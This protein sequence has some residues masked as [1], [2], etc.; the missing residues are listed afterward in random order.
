M[1]VGNV[2]LLIMNMPM[3]PV[4]AQVLRIPTFALYPFIFGLSM[5]AAYAPSER[6]FDVVLV[7][8]IGFVGFLMARLRFPMSPLILG[9][10]LGAM[11]ERSLRQ[12]LQMN[13]ND[14]TVLFNRPACLILIGL[15][16]LILLA[17]LLGRLMRK[18][19]KAVQ[20]T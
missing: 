4:F 15:G 17:P 3:V 9:F 8:V 7:V 10:V 20:L 2:V 16:T 12:T 6:I 5:V 19:A 13:Q 1:Y 18:P 11:M 14:L